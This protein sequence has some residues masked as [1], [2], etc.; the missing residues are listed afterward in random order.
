MDEHQRRTL[1]EQLRRWKAGEFKTKDI[2]YHISAGWFDWFWTDKELPSRTEKLYRMLDEIAS[3]DKFDNE[4][5]RVSFKGILTGAGELFDMLYIHDW[6]SGTCLFSI[7]T[8]HMQVNMFVDDGFDTIAD[9][10]D[11]E[12]I[13]SWFTG[14]TLHDAI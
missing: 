6:D 14:G 10:T 5:V 4:N 11:W 3:S 8:E 12:I 13:V 1:A 7:D 9:G 2:R